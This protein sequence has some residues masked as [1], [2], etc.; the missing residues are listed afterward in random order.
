MDLLDSQ[1]EGRLQD[2]LGFEDPLPGGGGIAGVE[3][4]IKASVIE[5]EML[6]VKALMRPFSQ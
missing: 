6:D 5:I 3:V 1:Q 4:N 2:R